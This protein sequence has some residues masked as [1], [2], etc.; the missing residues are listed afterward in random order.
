MGGLEHSLNEVWSLSL[1]ARYAQSE[2]DQKVQAIF[3]ADGAQ[4]DQP[5]VLPSSWALVDS[6][7]FQE[8]E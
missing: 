8:Q 4:A 6:E 7:L 5:L 2:F 1:K 3:G